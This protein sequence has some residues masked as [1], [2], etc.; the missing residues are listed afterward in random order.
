MLSCL[1]ETCRITS[2]NTRKDKTSHYKSK[3]S[4]PQCLKEHSIE[5]KNIE[6]FIE[7]FS[8]FLVRKRVIGYILTQ[9]SIRTLAL[10]TLAE[11]QVKFNW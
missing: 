9:K 11:N 4:S 3:K 5:R 7:F 2:Y 1:I 10:Q 6:K 8:P